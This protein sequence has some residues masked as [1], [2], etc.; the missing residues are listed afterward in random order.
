MYGTE[1]EPGLLPRVALALFQGI[2]AD[3]NAA[4]LTVAA[5]FASVYWDFQFIFRND[6]TL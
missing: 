6:V 4:A 2:A 3:P 1:L 5:S